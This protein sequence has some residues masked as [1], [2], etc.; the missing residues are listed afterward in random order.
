[1]QLILNWKNPKEWGTKTE[2][3][4]SGRDLEVYK[5]FSRMHKVCTT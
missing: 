4:Y 2:A 5:I 1:M 3:D